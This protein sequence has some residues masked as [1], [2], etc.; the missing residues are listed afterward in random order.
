MLCMNIC[1]RTRSYRQSLQ[2]HRTEYSAPDSSLP[3]ER[4]S[5]W[6][7]FFGLIDVKS[8]TCVHLYPR[9][10]DFIFELQGIETIGDDL[11]KIPIF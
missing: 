11:D 9:V 7:N 1:L 5:R 8:E 3:A 6:T 10:G 4:E 2:R